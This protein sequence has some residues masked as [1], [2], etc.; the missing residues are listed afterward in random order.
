MSLQKEIY[1][2]KEV[3]INRTLF[4]T[5]IFVILALSSSLLR[6]LEIGWQSIFTFHIIITIFIVSVYLV[7]NVIP[8]KIKAHILFIW[9]IL[10]GIIGL[11]NFKTLG[12]GTLQ[13]FIVIC[14]ST[15]VFGLRTGITYAVIFLLSFVVIGYLHIQNVFS[16]NI[17]FQEYINN[18]TT[19]F[20]HFTVFT[21]TIIILL[22]ITNHFYSFFISAYKEQAA[23][24][25]ELKKT[26]YDLSISEAKYRE[27][28][29][30]SKD[31][32]IMLDHE[33]RIKNCNQSYLN[34]IGYELEEL[35]GKDYKQLLPSKDFDWDAYVLE[36]AES[37]PFG[38]VVELETY[39][40]SGE[41]IPAEVSIYK[42][43][44]MSKP[45]LWGVVRDLRE[46]RA[47]ER[48]VFNA[49]ISAEENERERYA[50]ELHDGLGPILSTCMIY[51]NAIKDEKDISLI[52]DYANRA[53]NILE[54]ATKTVREI[55]NNLSPIILKEYG[56]VQAV[57]SFIEKV[58]HA[59]QI[60]FTIKDELDKRF[61]ETIEITIYRTLVELINNSLK[62]S[63][64]KNLS[65]SFLYNQQYGVLIQYQDDGQGFDYEKAISHKKGFGL[66]N[67]K[68]RIH[69]IGGEYSYQ[70]SPGQG[71][72]VSIKLSKTS[73]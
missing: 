44:F 13:V 21:F 46:K 59:T 43:D 25:E 22:I 62:Y 6:A 49:M 53:Y 41:L 36:V 57:R 20:N 50:K 35:I 5:V 16:T 67:L 71:V 34:F 17:N 23:I 33:Y 69:K 14:V 60:K 18:N 37:A 56:M 61:S 8:L 64:A 29:E 63:K 4:A 15:I 28:F 52:M 9:F 27:I 31:G 45:Y 40:K 51:N 42:A 3:I 68:H 2:V 11:I 58:G 12:S 48:Q 10:I 55:S 24:T 39:H 38:N 70:T 7:R 26:N 30:G 1:N 47:L 32:Y 72:K 73:T 66:L 19:W 54:D 65:I